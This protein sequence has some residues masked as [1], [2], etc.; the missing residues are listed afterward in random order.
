M[1]LEPTDVGYLKSRLEE[2]EDENEKL[3]QRVFALKS[4]LGLAEEL[5][6]AQFLLTKGESAIFSLMMRHTLCSK[7]MMT[8]V[9]ESL[10]LKSPLYAFIKLLRNKL[11]AHGIEVESI[12]G[13]GWG[14]SLANKKRIREM[15]CPQ[16]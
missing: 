13:Q 4:A 9:L 5:P 12:Y 3:R 15:S 2:V 11:K 7:E 14:I 16:N 8:A 10:E 6:P 1:N